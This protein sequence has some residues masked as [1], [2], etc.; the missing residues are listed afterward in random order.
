MENRV[1]YQGIIGSFSSMAARALYGEDF[2][3]IQT[4]RFR[5]IFEAIDQG[6]ADYGVIPLENALAGS[7]HENYDLL[8]EYECYVVAEHFCPVHLHLMGHGTLASITRVLSHPKALEQCSRFLE[9]H[10]TITAVVCS[11]TAGAALQVA[12]IK[13]PYSAAIASEEA[14]TTYRL[15]IIQRSIQNHITN[16]TRFVAIA[17]SPLQCASPT[18][19]SVVVSLPHEPGSLHKLLGHIAS[20]SLNITKIE[21]RPILGKPFEYAFHMDLECSPDLSPKLQEGLTRIEQYASTFRLLGVY[22]ARPAA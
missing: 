20:L 4:S 9:I 15:P 21:S 1:A 3:P 11:D 5:D 10:S 8:Q 13:D 22:E 12:R 6:N 14:A 2:T 7:V 19:C 16:A 18:K 17:K